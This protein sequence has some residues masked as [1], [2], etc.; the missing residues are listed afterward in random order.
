MIPILVSMILHQPV[1][2]HASACGEDEKAD[3]FFGSVDGETEMLCCN[4]SSHRR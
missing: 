4:L 3:D 2:H 1:G